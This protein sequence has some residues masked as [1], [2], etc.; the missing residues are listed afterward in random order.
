[1][2]RNVLLLLVASVLVF[3]LV[4]TAFAADLKIA[5]VNSD[6]ILAGFKEAQ[7]A[8]AKLDIEAKK[9]Q[10]EYQLML[11]KLDS[12]NKS[13]ERQKMIMS[14]SR[15]KEK[16]TEMLQL[17][18]SIQVFQKDKMGP[19]GEIYR[20]QNEII[21]PVLEKVKKVI[22]EVASENNYDFVFDTVAGN[23]LYAEPVHDITEKILYQLERSKE[24]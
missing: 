18:Q 5:F 22:S 3:G 10:D 16:E 14:E 20:K 17:Q 1:V 9:I 12:L 23:I 7:E 11:V 19:Q 13:Y 2:K 4:N 24:E 8:Q 15:R 21:G 6:Q